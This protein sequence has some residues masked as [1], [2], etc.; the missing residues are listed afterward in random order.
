MAH[1]VRWCRSVV[2]THAV[3]T[4]TYTV[5]LVQDLAPGG[6]LQALLDARGGCLPEPEAAAA[7]AGVLDA[8]VA[9]H[10]EG[11][12]YGDVQPAS[13]GRAA[14]DEGL[15]RAVGGFGGLWGLCM[16]VGGSAAH[17]S[18]GGSAGV[19]PPLPSCLHAHVTL[20]PLAS[21]R[22]TSQTLCWP[23]PIPRP[24]FPPSPTPRRP[25]TAW[26]QRWSTLA[27]RAPARAT[28][29]SRA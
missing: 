23:R 22:P 20:V 5:Y 24:A 13:G 26:R 16:S 3:H 18:V 9:C 10:S 11:V 2:R 29:R 4:D 8:L 17:M 27:A 21:P 1:R 19:H 12:C 6:S 15:A 28:A 14:G 25:P 7:L